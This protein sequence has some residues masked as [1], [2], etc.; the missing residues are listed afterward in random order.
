M[1]F[2]PGDPVWCRVDPGHEKLGSIGEIA[3][4]V[5]E[6][7]IMLIGWYIIDFE[8]NK[9]WAAPENYLR[10]RNPPV[11]EREQ[12]GEWELC[13]W[14]PLTETVTGSPHE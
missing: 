6:P 1:S 11:R 13:P 3:A 8:G 9:G 7:H 2:K 4:V 5:V 10:P 12:L 14:R